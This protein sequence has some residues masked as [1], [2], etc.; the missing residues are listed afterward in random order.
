MPV[1][2]VPK[3]LYDDL[4]K[5]GEDPARFVVEAAEEKWGKVLFERALKAKEAAD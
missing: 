4:V 3:D 5:A 1:I 2:Y